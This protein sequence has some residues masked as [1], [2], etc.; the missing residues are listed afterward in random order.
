MEIWIGLKGSIIFAI[1]S[2]TSFIA[3]TYIVPL[4]GGLLWG[5]PNPSTTKENHLKL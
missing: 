4:Q 2:S 1:P 5:A 3:G